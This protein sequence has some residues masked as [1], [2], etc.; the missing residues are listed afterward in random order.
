MEKQVKPSV[1]KWRRGPESNRRI[2]VLQTSIHWTEHLYYQLTN[3]QNW[4]FGQLS[5][6]RARGAL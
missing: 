4:P 1:L 2:K 5:S 6:S 3:P